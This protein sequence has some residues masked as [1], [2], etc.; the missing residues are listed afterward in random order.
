VTPWL[1]TASGAR[2]DLVTP[3]PSTI[4]LQDVA[5]ALAHLGRFTGH[6]RTLYTIAQHSVLGAR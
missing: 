3:E 5:H 4:V 2:Y 6:A 1:Q